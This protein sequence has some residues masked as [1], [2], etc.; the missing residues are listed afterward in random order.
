[1][2]IVRWHNTRGLH[3]WSALT[4]LD[5]ELGRVFGRTACAGSDAEADWVP[6]ADVHETTDA[7][8]LELDLP[9][10]TREDVALSVL[11]DTLTISGER[12]D[13]RTHDAERYHRNERRLGTFERHFEFPVPIDAA[14]VAADYDNGVLK[15][16][17]PKREDARPKQIEIKVN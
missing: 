11:D 9:G 14:Q 17:L 13:E 3:P 6:A 1:M 10:M 12:K 7:Y 4:E 16:T 2:S 5:R 8:T 15:V